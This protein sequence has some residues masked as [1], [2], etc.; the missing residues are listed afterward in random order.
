[1]PMQVLFVCA[2]AGVGLDAWAPNLVGLWLLALTAQ[3]ACLVVALRRRLGTALCSAACMLWAFAAWAAWQTGPV[4]PSVTAL[5]APPGAWQVQV[6]T[7]PAPRDDRRGGPDAA[8]QGGDVTTVQL[9]AQARDGLWRPEV[10]VVRLHLRPGPAVARG[11]VLQLRLAVRGLRDV[12]APWQLDAV[13]RRRRQGI[14]A[15]ATVCGLHAVVVRAQGLGPWADTLRHRAAHRMSA[16]MPA[17]AAAIARA[18]ALGDTLG[19]SPHQ[20][21]AWAD[22]GMAHLLAVSGLHVGLVARAVRGGAWSLLALQPKFAERIS[23]RRTA[24]ALA[25]PW[26]WA[27]ALFTGAAV[28]AQRSAWMATWA[29]GC[30]MAGRGSALAGHNLALAGLAVLCVDP[31][32]A[33]SPGFWLSFVSV[34][35]LLSL[36]RPALGQARP[37]GADRTWRG[38]LSAWGR[39]GLKLLGLALA[40]GVVTSVGTAPMSAHFF[41]RI[42]LVSPLTNLVAVPLG[43]ALA[44]PLAILLAMAT[45]W[46]GGAQATLLAAWAW[47]TARVLLALDVLATWGQSLPW[48]A[49]TVGPNQAA[50][51][52]VLALGWAWVRAQAWA[53]SWGFA[54]SQRLRR[55]GL[56]S[57]LC[58]VAL[59][60]CGQGLHE[61]ASRGRLTL[62]HLDVG[63]GDATLIRL[64]D[65]SWVLV[66]A[67]GAIYPGAGDPGRYAVGPALLGLGVRRLRA[68][69]L[70]HPHPDHMGGLDYVLSRWPVDTFWRNADAAAMPAVQALDALVRAG[71][72]KAGLP[73]GGT[74]T[75]AGVQV[76]PHLP[77]AHRAA[78]VNDHSIVLQLTWGERRAL[79]M[80]D[81]EAAAEADILADLMPAE[82]LKLGHHG[83]R[84]STT[85]AL[86][87]R[88]R[89][90]F[91]VA[92]CGEDNTFGHPHAVTLARLLAASVPVLRTDS[93]GTLKLST[94]GD[95]PWQLAHAGTHWLDVQTPCG[96]P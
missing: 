7:T 93:M 79:L 73:P 80:G 89:P 25:L 70:T 23:L 43:S 77:L 28:S 32:S 1:M 44:T 34:A 24:A 35:C 40:V 66:D 83:S 85:Q 55:L 76:T 5:G 22:A 10:G 88:I 37:A 12:A 15:R 26:V 17:R 2:L 6:M 71:G 4:G 16:A 92:S 59:W 27:Y 74:I 46:P 9:L 47:A 8:A 50:V 39:R 67:G 29:L 49:I 3:S 36:P 61:R 81:A 38:R 94:D 31:L 45:N 60:A 33:G 69:V 53:Q 21:D 19:L 58:L 13:Q 72:G 54:P 86:L 91:A 48:A 18:L 68:V 62:W 95:D 57:A 90:C 14:S 63:Q 56:G 65:N 41:G 11:D 96:D 84:T 52:V 64:P 30:E 82:V 87:E 78:S 42:S 75:W 51:C 20:R